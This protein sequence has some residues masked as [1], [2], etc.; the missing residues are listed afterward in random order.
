MNFRPN[1]IANEKEVYVMIE[2]QNAETAAN[3]EK[4]FLCQKDTAEILLLFD[5]LRAIFKKLEVF[6]AVD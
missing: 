4:C 5:K 1:P 3:W 2:E 6:A